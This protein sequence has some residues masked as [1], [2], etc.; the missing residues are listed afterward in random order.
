MFAS[1]R[2]C[3]SSLLLAL[4]LLTAC[5]REDIQARRPL[6]VIAVHATPETNLRAHCVSAFNPAIDYFPEKVT[7]HHATQ[8]SVT[9][10]GHYKRLVFRPNVEREATEEFLLVQCGTP[11]PPHD[12]RTR[13]ISVPAQRFVLTNLA[14]VSAAVRMGLLDSL[15][16]VSSMNGVSHPDVIE[17]HKRGFISE[18]GTGLH[19]SVET[20]MATDTQLLFTFYSAWPNY[21]THPKLW[22]VGIQ[23]LPTADHFEQSNLGRTE[24]IKFLALFF[25]RERE[26]NEIFTPA[27]KRYLELRQLTAN[28]SERPDVL[29]GWP[30]GRDI[31]NLNGGRN[32]FAALIADAG[33]RYFWNDNVSLSLIPTNLE[34]VFDEQREARVYISRSYTAPNRA[35]LAAKNPVMPAL[36]AFSSNQIWSPDKNTSVHRRPPWQDQSLDQP[37]VVLKDLIAALHPELLPTYEPY[38]LRKLD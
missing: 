32:F 23:G 8:F 16:G 20:A 14:F 6:P 19:S 34:Q 9:Y 17:R 25:N 1:S 22:E 29:V 4:S 7:V 13:V 26:A 33:G 21:N 28:V 37:D 31:W 3:I 38:F 2:A 35:A 10:H 12:A 5:R 15:I 11:V 27:A 30:S 24:W 18:V 36:R